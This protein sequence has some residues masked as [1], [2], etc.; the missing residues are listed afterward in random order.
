M[1]LSEWLS[2]VQRRALRIKN[3]VTSAPPKMKLVFASWVDGDVH[4]KHPDFAFISYPKCGRTWVRFMLARAIQQEHGYRLNQH[5]LLTSRL[6]HHLTGKQ[7]LIAHYITR[8][9]PEVKRVDRADKA[10]FT[11][12]PVVLLI[13]DI[14]D[15]LVS[16]Y[17]HN[18]QL[19]NFPEMTLSEFIRYP[20]LGID[21]LLKYYQGW[22]H[23]R[24]VPSS[25]TLVRYEDVRHNTFETMRFMADSL[26]MAKV[27]DESLRLGIED[28][29]FEKMR[30]LEETGQIK[31]LNTKWT[32]SSK[33]LNTRRIRQ[34]KVAG[35]H[36]ELTADD[37]TYIEERVTASGLPHDWLYYPPSDTPA[38]EQKA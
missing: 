11:G 38:A 19:K 32:S 1:N 4:P 14:R 8:D 12:I 23:Y 31:H 10:V 3:R 5:Y 25:L 18:T 22:Y 28:G 30:V 33:S 21:G 7:V 9:R 6:Y 16:F 20:K 24:D 13:R 15:T 35:Y 27:S 36:A 34:G 26:G 17:Y 2:K 37:L 29:R